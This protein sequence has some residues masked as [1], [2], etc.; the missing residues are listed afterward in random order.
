[1]NQQIENTKA[2]QE[3]DSVTKIIY[4][5]KSMMD[6]VQRELKIAKTIGIEKYNQ[7]YSPSSYKF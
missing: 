3:L 2:F 4:S 5:R 6:Q 1:M 7:L